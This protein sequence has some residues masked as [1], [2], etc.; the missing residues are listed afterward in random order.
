MKTV[1]IIGGFG[2]ETT[3]AFQLEIVALCAA[4]KLKERPPILMWNTPIPLKIEDKLI[5]KG[6]G[7]DKFLPF[8]ISGAKML[9]K[10][11]S[12][13]LVFP[14]NTLHIF[15]HEI[16]KAVSIP[17]ISIVD[18]MAIS[19]KN[20]G[21]KKIGLIG[22][23]IT[24]ESNMHTDKLRALGV[25]TVI[26]S[27]VDQVHIDRIIHNILNQKDIVKSKKDIGRIANR[28]KIQGIHH[29]LLACTD[30]QL[31]FPSIP[32]LSVHDTMDV[33]A[34]AAVREITL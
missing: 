26:P 11:G 16:R 21:I 9:E 32:G 19:L 3:A 28:F 13:F 22:T 30:L 33:L 15:I 25:K 24:I 6:G 29:I 34:R 1:G 31:L 7:A 4:Q 20:N 18:E 27:K 23:K 17:V 10:S 5:L 14:C 2:P 12:D 8:L